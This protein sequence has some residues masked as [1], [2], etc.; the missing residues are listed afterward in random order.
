MQDSSGRIIAADLSIFG[1]NFH[2]VN[3]YAPVGG[4]NS[5]NDEQNRFYKS[6]KCFSYHFGW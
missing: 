3:V 1:E 5:P 2:V 4:T 6:V